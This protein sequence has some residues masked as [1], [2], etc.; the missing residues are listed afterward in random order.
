MLLLE[1]VKPKIVL[2][3]DFEVFAHPSLIETLLKWLTEEDWQVVLSTHSID[4]LYA[5]LSI[6]KNTRKI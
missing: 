5:L 1:A 4:I 2:W 3:D 6:K